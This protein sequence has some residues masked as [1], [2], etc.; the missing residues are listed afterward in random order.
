MVF[1]Q[2]F[3]AGASTHFQ[4]PKVPPG[5]GLS[6]MSQGIEK[7]PLVPGCFESFAAGGCFVGSHLEDICCEP[8]QEGQISRA[9]ILSISGAVFMEYD[10][11]LPMTSI[12]DVPMI[13]DDI[14]EVKRRE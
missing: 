4:N 9:V 7:E 3:G 12:I 2:L 13:S 6:H 8:A 1:G 10:V 14:E 11:L 5:A